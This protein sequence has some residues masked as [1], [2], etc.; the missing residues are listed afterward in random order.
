MAQD[1][2]SNNGLAY[3]DMP[4][5]TSNMLAIAL[6]PWACKIKLFDGRNYFIVM[7]S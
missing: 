1:Y 3:Y 2:F 6:T 7:Q 5:V 4:Q